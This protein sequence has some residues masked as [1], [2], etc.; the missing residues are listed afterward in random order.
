L[1]STWPGP[2]GEIYAVSPS[3]SGRYL[4]QGAPATI[5]PIAKTGAMLVFGQERS[6]EKTVLAA[7]P[8]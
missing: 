4:F 6:K 7:E 5:H 8:I 3:G 2:V 1:N